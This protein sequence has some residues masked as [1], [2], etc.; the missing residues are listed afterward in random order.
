MCVCVSFSAS[1]SMRGLNRVFDLF[2]FEVKIDFSATVGDG[3]VFSGGCAV[4]RSAFII[5]L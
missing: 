5:A 3:V 1:P 2:S 4:S